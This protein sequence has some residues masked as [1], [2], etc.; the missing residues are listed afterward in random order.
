PRAVRARLA[1]EA[2][3]GDGWYKYV[4]LDGAVI[5][6]TSF[7]ASAPADA[8]MAQ[9]GFTAANVVATAEALLA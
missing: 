8:L 2:A 4:G 7:G 6:M 1:V 5:G 9:F 3:Q